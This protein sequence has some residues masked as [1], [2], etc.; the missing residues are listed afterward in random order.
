ME[1]YSIHKHIKNM[2][3]IYSGLADIHASLGNYQQ[4]YHYNE[5]YN[6]LRISLLD[7]EKARALDMIQEFEKDR[8]QAEIDLL[9]KD[10]EIQDLN[11]RKQK[12]IRNS[13]AGAGAFVLLLII[14]LWH[15]YRVDEDGIVRAAR[16]VPPTSQI[17]RHHLATSRR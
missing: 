10:A 16:I 15:R 2:L 9:T 4:A 12:I 11:I 6:N 8:K 17:R 3:E 7:E 13:L 5:A 14:L 1:K